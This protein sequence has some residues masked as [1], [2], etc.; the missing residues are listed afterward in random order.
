[1]FTLEDLK[2]VKPERI[3]ETY[4]DIP[5]PDMKLAR[6]G[7]KISC[8]FRSLFS[9]EYLKLMASATTSSG[10]PIAW[11]MASMSSILVAHCWVDENGDRVMPD[12]KMV[13]Q[14]FWKQSSPGFLEAM[15][16]KAR[17][18][19]SVVAKDEDEDEEKNAESP[20]TE[21]TE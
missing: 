19:C 18:I 10:K 15:V 4:D 14:P 5:H 20:E 21:G 7:V 12:D 1:M 16:A 8:R 13:M 2:N 3:C 9:S 6:D 11:R 17:E